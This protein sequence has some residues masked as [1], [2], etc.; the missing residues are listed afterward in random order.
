MPESPIEQFRSPEAL[1][2][3]RRALRAEQAGRVG[4]VLIVA[5]ALAGLF[6]PGPLSHSTAA[7]DDGGLEVAYSRFLRNGSTTGVD[8]T[9]TLD[10]PDAEPRL[11]VE[12]DYLDTFTIEDVRPTPTEVIAH[13]GRL[14]FVFA[15]PG[16]P[17]VEIAFDLRPGEFGPR[18]GHVETGD[19]ST[20]TVS[21][22]IYP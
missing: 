14:E 4:M 21:Q 20:A 12:R 16:T 11:F 10:D 2:H 8:A 5:A 13:A 9:L 17:V 6:G 7:S 22:F 19:G 18:S 1:R 3:Q 15:P